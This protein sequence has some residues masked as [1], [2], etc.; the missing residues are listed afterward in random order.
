MKKINITITILLIA[1]IITGCTKTYEI[2]IDHV[3]HMGDVRG[4]GKYEE[5]SLATL[6]AIPNDGYTFK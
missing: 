3:S 6:E 1:L 4:A 5:D 2:N